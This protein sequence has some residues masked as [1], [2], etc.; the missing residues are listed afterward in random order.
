MGELGALRKKSM[1]IFNK[2]SIQATKTKNK[3]KINTLLLKIQHL[4]GGGAA[5]VLSWL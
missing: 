2:F 4:W 5:Y 1:N 3:P